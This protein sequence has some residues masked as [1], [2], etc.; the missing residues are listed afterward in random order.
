MVQ[1]SNE[2]GYLATKALTSYGVDLPCEVFIVCQLQRKNLSHLIDIRTA[3]S[4]ITEA[5][6]TQ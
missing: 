6:K 3:E 2:E 4:R 5:G 1:I